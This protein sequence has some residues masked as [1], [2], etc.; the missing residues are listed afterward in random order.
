MQ[1]EASIIMRWSFICGFNALFGDCINDIHAL[2]ND[3]D[4]HL[5]LSEIS[6]A[7]S[8]KTQEMLV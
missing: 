7:I 6:N 3:L 8:K 2:V 4:Q 1:Y 5:S